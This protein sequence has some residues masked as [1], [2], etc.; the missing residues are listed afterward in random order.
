MAA[1]VLIVSESAAA[2]EGL[3]G[4]LRRAGAFT[5]TL[6][7]S[8]DEAA[9]IVRSLAVDLVLVDARRADARRVEIAAR[10]ER[11]RPGVRVVALANFGAI[12]N[13]A[14]MLQFGT[15]DFVVGTEQVARL[16]EAGSASGR[17]DAD[18][19]AQDRGVQALVQ[20]VDVLVGLLEIDDPDRGGMTHRAQRLA[21]SVAGEMGLEAEVIH[22]IVLATLLRDI[23]RSTVE[24]DLLS[25]SSA[26]STEEHERVREHVPGSLRLLGH[27][28]FPW[29]VLPIIRHHHECYDGTGYPDGLRGREIP[30]GARIIGAVEAYVAMLS[31]RPYRRALSEDEASAELM[32]YAG[33]QFDPEVVEALLRVLDRQVSRLSAPSGP[34]VVLADPG[35]DSTAAFRLRL[36]NQGLEVVPADGFDEAL[37]I[38][39]QRA[40]HL[41]AVS[42]DDD[43]EGALRLLR[44]IRRDRGLEEI[45][46]AVLADAERRALRLRAFRLGA[47]DVLPAGDEVEEV[48]ARVENLVAREAA[49]RGEPSRRAFH[50]G[51]SGRLESMPVPEIVQ[52]LVIGTKTACL[53]LSCDGRSGR[54]FFDHGAVV[55]ARTDESEGEAA[56]FRMLEWGAGEFTIEHGL[57][58]PVATIEQDPTFLLMEGMR[59]IDERTADQAGD[60]ADAVPNIA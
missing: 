40:P 38:V 20:V 60:G 14:E 7:E 8:L 56:F 27:I 16:I 45:P 2:R 44:E 49:R 6:A 31:H 42:A 43:E 47:D 3:A 18:A 50:H 36:L 4:A 54:V 30:I 25:R 5:P 37:A 1:R 21:R 48:V 58:S 17:G 34:V 23:G 28:D 29:K 39:R 11:E 53:T 26:L 24:P 15:G 41:V 12:R 9:R 32:R 46:V 33:Q 10:L 51:I 13:S 57:R 22:E 52:T 55:D 35:G 19:E 59:R